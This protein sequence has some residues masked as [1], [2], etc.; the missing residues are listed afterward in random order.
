MALEAGL[1]TI[2]FR[3]LAPREVVELARGCGLTA[4]EGGGAIH[5]P[6]GDAAN[7]R[8]VSRMT[9]DAGL[10]VKAYGSYLRLGEDDPS[11]YGGVIDAAAALEAPA[12]RV[13]AGR[14]PSSKA[15]EAY[16]RRVADAAREF[17]T[18]AAAAGIVT[19]FEFHANSLTDTDES[20]LALLRATQDAGVRT[21]W[22][23]PHERNVDQNRQSLRTMLPWLNHVHVFHWP[24]WGQ[25]APLAEGADR[26]RAYL[27]LLQDQRCEV[28]LLLDFVRGDARDQLRADA[29]TLREWIA[30]NRI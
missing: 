15:D 6:P 3:K 28:P 1:V 26:W 17:A 10:T 11:T 5:V 29:V 12:I 4:L 20:A 14:W 30:E 18:L 27:K 19:C 16:R 9:A 23:P 8:E 22:Q 21:L 2:T 25:R 24:V 7:A 13:W